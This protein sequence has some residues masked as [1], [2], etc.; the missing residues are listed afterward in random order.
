MLSRKIPLDAAPSEITPT[1]ASRGLAGPIPRLELP[2]GSMSPASAYRLI[3]DEL[4]LDSIPSL[5]L[6][7]FVA[8]YMDDAADRL[9]SRSLPARLPRQTLLLWRS[10]TA[11]HPNKSTEST[12]RRRPRQICAASHAIEDTINLRGDK[13]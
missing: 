10:K 1:Y 7:S 4:A 12:H 13:S 5:N 8:T 11:L 6:A 3:H 9:I 2:E